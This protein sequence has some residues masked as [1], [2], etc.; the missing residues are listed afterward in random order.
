[1]LKV[2]MY[3]RC[4]IDREYPDNPRSF[5]TGKI[6]G[7]DEFNECV[8]IKFYDPYG[9]KAYFEYV[10]DEVQEAPLKMID[11]CH[12]FKGAVVKYG[13][14]DAV[15]VEYKATKNDFTVYY[16]Q[17]SDTKE[18]RIMLL[19]KRWML[20]LQLVVWSWLMPLM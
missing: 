20:L 6:L 5:A 8:R 2:G 11:R 13:H 9:Y 3:V 17:T 16:L 19:R 12:L 15:I 18:F 7:I 14:R 1:M 4:P 10:P